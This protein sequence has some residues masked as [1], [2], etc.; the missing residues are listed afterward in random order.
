MKNREIPGSPRTS[1]VVP[2]SLR[3]VY[4]T[5]Y[6]TALQGAPRGYEPGSCG[7]GA[8]P[9]LSAPVAPQREP[10]NEVLGF[11]GFDFYDLL[12][13]PKVSWGF[14][15]GFPRIWFRFRFDFDLIWFWFWFD[16]GFDF[17]SIWFWFW[18]GLILMRF[19]LDLAWFWF[20]LPWFWL[21]LVWFRLD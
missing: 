3:V 2:R 17:D 16:F 10:R 4:C 9:G 11:L 5:L 20:D 18:F 19:G 8:V 14:L 13:F 7:P 15:P 12:S 21:D 6:C 1:F